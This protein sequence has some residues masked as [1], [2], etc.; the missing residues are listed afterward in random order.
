MFGEITLTPDRFSCRRCSVLVVLG[1]DPK[2]YSSELREQREQELCSAHWRERK[3]ELQ[4][5]VTASSNTL[6]WSTR[7]T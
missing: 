7:S 5:C 1:E 2:R 6:T 4:P 3:Q